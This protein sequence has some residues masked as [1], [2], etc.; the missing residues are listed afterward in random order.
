MALGE[1]NLAVQRFVL[2]TCGFQADN[3]GL[4]QARQVEVLNVVEDLWLLTLR[5]AEHTIAV[6]Q[7]AL[8]L[9]KADGDQA[10]E[11]CIGQGLNHSSKALLLNAATQLGALLGNAGLER[12]PPNQQYVA[13]LFDT[14]R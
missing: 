13:R 12:L 1:Q 10:V 6:A 5:V 7:V 9:H 11:P 14:N 8:K 3:L 4:V 2:I